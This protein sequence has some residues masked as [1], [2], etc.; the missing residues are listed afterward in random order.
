M[1]LTYIKTI[2]TPWLTVGEKSA[3]KLDNDIYDTLGTKKFDFDKVRGKVNVFAFDKPLPAYEYGKSYRPKD[4]L[5]IYPYD[6]NII[7]IA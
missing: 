4:T 2:S 3:E 5:E 7:L 1:L 6:G